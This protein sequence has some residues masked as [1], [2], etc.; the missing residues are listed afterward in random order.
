MMDGK[1]SRQPSI[2]LSANQVLN[3]AVATLCLLT[4]EAGIER[5]W[6]LQAMCGLPQ[7]NWLLYSGYEAGTVMCTAQVICSGSSCRH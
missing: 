6:E 7:F 4:S 2:S 1:R 3:D 5:S